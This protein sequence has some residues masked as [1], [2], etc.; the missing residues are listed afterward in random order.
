VDELIPIIAERYQQIAQTSGEEPSLNEKLRYL[1]GSEHIINDLYDEEADSDSDS[2]SGSDSDSYVSQ[3]STTYSIEKMLEQ[4]KEQNKLQSAQQKRQNI[5][6]RWLTSEHFKYE[7]LLLSLLSDL[8]A[9]QEKLAQLEGENY[10]HT[11]LSGLNSMHNDMQLQLSKLTNETERDELK[12]QIKRLKI[13]GSPFFKLVHYL[14]NH[15]IIGLLLVAAIV[16]IA[17]T[18][19]PIVIGVGAIFS[20]VALNK[21]RKY[22]RR[23]CKQAPIIMDPSQS[24]QI[25]EILEPQINRTHSTKPAPIETCGIPKPKSTFILLAHFMT[26]VKDKPPTSE[27]EA[28]YKQEVTNHMSR[29]ASR[30]IAFIVVSMSLLVPT[31]VDFLS[32]DVGLLS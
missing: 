26:E 11:M 2:D 28:A 7:S 25:Q 4:A 13:N 14:T 19:H 5:L 20:I 24:E 15:K 16:L 18:Q 31:L 23:D 12:N 29:F 27:E 3:F 8:F 10:L 32:C 9:F 22:L 6:Q 21:T 30:A 1:F 17:I